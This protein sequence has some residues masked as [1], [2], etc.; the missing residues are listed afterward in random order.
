MTTIHSIQWRNT[1]R[2]K[3][4]LHSF[5]TS[6]PGEGE[7]SASWSSRFTVGKERRY[8]LK[9][10]LGGSPSRYR[11]IWRTKSLLVLLGFESRTVQVAAS[12]IPCRLQEDTDWIQAALNITAWLRS[13]TAYLQTS[14]VTKRQR[15]SFRMAEET[16]Q[17]E[18]S[19]LFRSHSHLISCVYLCHGWRP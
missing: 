5:L 15:I 3:V 9:K 14:L 12:R 8:S 19:L 16:Q 11:R 7:W 10:S 6:A 18:Y 2:T 17:Y 1:G 4:K 13:T